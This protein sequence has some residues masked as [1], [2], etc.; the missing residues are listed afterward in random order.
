MAI[1]GDEYRAAQFWKKFDAACEP[2]YGGGR[3]EY[4]RASLL[5]FFVT[6]CTEQTERL[7]P[8]LVGLIADVR[9]SRV[10][11]QDFD[12]LWDLSLAELFAALDIH[13]SQRLSNTRVGL[14]LVDAAVRLPERPDLQ[15]DGDDFGEIFD[16]RFLPLAASTND[17]DARQAHMSGVLA[18]TLRGDGAPLIDG[19]F[20]TGELFATA[21]HARWRNGKKQRRL[22]TIKQVGEFQLETSL[23]LEIRGV[24]V[25]AIERLEHD[26][27]INSFNGFFL[28]D[29]LHAPPL[30]QALRRSDPRLI[31]IADSGTAAQMLHALLN[32]NINFEGVVVVSGV[33][34]SRGPN[35]VRELRH[36]LVL[37]H[38]LVAVIDLPK[39]RGGARS[40]W[41]LGRRD[42]FND[43]TLMVNLEVLRASGSKRELGGLAEFSGRLVRAFER[44]EQESRWATV[45]T[46]KDGVRLRQLFEREFASGY[47]D[48]PGLCRAVQ[49]DELFDRNL[50]LQASKYIAEPEQR[51]FLAGIN[52]MPLALQLDASRARVFYVIGN[53]G[54]GKSFMLRE[55]AA[56]ATSK[57]GRAVGVASGTF[58]R[59]QFPI[60]S[61]ASKHFVY[62][63]ARTSSDGTS[64]KRLSEELCRKL[65]SIHCS[66]QRLEAF[67]QV[68]ETLQFARHA[69]VVPSE[70]P[71]RGPSLAFAED[72]TEL[73]SDV[74]QNQY[75]LDEFDV[76]R[77]QAAFS[78]TRDQDGITPFTELSSGEQQ[79]LSLL[80]KCVASAS[81]GCLMLVDEPEISLHVSWQRLLP[82][83]FRQIA[84][85]FDSNIVVA[86]HSPVVVASAQT[87]GDRCYAA[88]GQ[89]LNELETSLSIESVLFS[90]FGTYTENNRHVHERCAAL[91]AA[92]A[93][94][95][96]GLETEGV[97]F[98]E[99]MSE[100]NEMRRTITKTHRVDSASRPLRLIQLAR[101]ALQQIRELKGHAQL[102][103][104]GDAA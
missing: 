54:E 62:E 45:D 6:R 5:V 79:V 34:R 12:R 100:L 29:A 44:A 8:S 68:L 21:G 2:L 86:T 81:N 37:S 55:L 18:N 41:V 70:R 101:N 78:R 73:S 88:S 69:Y 38:R 97:T 30:P 89:E 102:P 52:G 75:M 42:S 51:G 48:V 94:R 36:E 58:D 46:G 96:N 104:D 23:R 74:A 84:E 56:R 59:F 71:G 13:Q 90:G 19:F 67:R 50:A 82:L 1:D 31:G 24:R 60:T 25:Q 35:W 3:G 43:A 99:M 40:A 20:S 72:V 98:D 16:Y 63:G 7:A 66:Y 64:L 65:I 15:E 83:A 53:N 57:G 91:V 77:R 33:D 76:L 9:S 47:K 32:E 10:R 87:D 103:S 85:H 27:R 49:T 92:A 80:I 22:A 11:K 95:A 28:I 17:V 4:L 14:P 61:L 26:K 39:T 93:K